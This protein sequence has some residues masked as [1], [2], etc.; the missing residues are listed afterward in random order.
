MD[1]KVDFP[2][3]FRRRLDESKRE[4]RRRLGRTKWKFKNENLTKRHYVS[5]GQ[6]QDMRY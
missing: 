2:V 5:T 1:L 4:E 6:S 3:V